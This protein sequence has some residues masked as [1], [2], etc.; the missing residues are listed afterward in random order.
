MIELITG[1]KNMQDITLKSEGYSIAKYQNYFD[2][3]LW[4]RY[5]EIRDQDQ[6]GIRSNRNV[7]Y[8]ALNI[9]TYHRE[10]FISKNLSQLM[11]SRFFDPLDKRY[12]SHLHIFITDN[13]SEIHIVK[14]PFVHISHNHNTGGA[15]GFQK[16]LE[17]IRKSDIAFSHVIFMDDDV[18]F[19]NESFY[20]LFDFLSYLKPE[21]SGEVV[22]GRMF[23]MDKPWIQYTAAEIWNAGELKHVG[24]Q[25]DI[26]DIQF[27]GATKKL[28]NDNTHAEYGGWWFCCFPMEFCMKNDIL[29]F[30]IHCDDAEYGLRHGGRPIVINGIQVWHETF[31]KR[32]TP[33]ILYYD[34]RNS[35]FVN[36]IYGF[37]PEWKTVLED[38]KKKITKFH[39]QRDWATEYYVILAMNDF[40]K[41]INWLKRV[42]PEKYQKKLKRIKSC[43]IKNAVCWRI[44]ERRFKRK[45]GL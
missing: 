24:F 34:I 25:Q 20:R 5:T 21:Y 44:V 28:I 35:L 4:G 39:I 43:K 14:N 9:C 37:I 13:A 22:A 18:T 27:N 2:A 31:E 6:I 30:F 10:E 17:E 16:G 7:I 42:D 8:L 26:S 1:S 15:G 36:Q 41:G 38:W 19:L 23:R 32:Q 29:P 40:I 33:L 12:F 11:R 3:E 45:F